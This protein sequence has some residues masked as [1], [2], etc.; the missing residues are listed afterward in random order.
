MA[1]RGERTCSRESG[2]EEDDDGDENWADKFIDSRDLYI[3]HWLPAVCSNNNKKNTR[4][5]SQ[6]ASRPIINW[7][8]LIQRVRWADGLVCVCGGSGR[9]ILLLPGTTTTQSPTARVSYSVYRNIV[10]ALIRFPPG[11]WWWRWLSV[12]ES[13][14]LQTF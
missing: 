1:R 3:N 5:S 2:R 9:G 4:R 7:P 13:Q 11:R 6:R 12:P 14:P 8:I 10:D